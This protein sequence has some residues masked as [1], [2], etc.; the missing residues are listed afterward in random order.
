MVRALRVDSGGAAIADIDDSEL[1]EGDVTVDVEFSSVNFKDG[2]A[3]LGRPGVLRQPNRI[4]GIDLVGTVSASTSPRW[5]PGDRVLLNGH[6]IG[7]GH[8]GGLAE[9]ARVRS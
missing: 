8:P 1:G 7:E 4:P 9:S 6:G 3:L 2:L 5:S